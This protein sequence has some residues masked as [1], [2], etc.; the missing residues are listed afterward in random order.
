MSIQV[1]GANVALPENAT[2]GVSFAQDP[3]PDGGRK[4]ISADGKPCRDYWFSSRLL[5]FGALGT[6]GLIGIGGTK[7]SFGFPPC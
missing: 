3:T 1:R 6:A 2:G 7:F 4:F 5:G